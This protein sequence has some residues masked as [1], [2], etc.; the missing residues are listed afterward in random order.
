MIKIFIQTRVFW[1]CRCLLH[2]YSS[3]LYKNWNQNEKS[4]EF[5]S[6]PT[7]TLQTYIFCKHQKLETCGSCSTHIV[8]LCNV[9]VIFRFPDVRGKVLLRAFPLLQKLLF[10]SESSP[11]WCFTLIILSKCFSSCGFIFL[12]SCRR[13]SY[14]LLYPKS[15]AEVKCLA[16]GGA[17]VDI[18]DCLFQFAKLKFMGHL[19]LAISHMTSSQDCLPGNDSHCGIYLWNLVYRSTF[20]K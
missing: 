11:R 18:I 19:G 13:W 20:Q 3:Q 12:Q 4:K 6:M 16:A 14:P 1:S 8:H 7:F 10:L 17:T 2:L 15:T 5:P 9:Y